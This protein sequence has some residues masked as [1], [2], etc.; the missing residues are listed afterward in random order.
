MIHI[1]F[2]NVSD[3]EIANRILR[4]II[5]TNYKRFEFHRSERNMISFYFIEKKLCPDV[6][7]Y[8]IQIIIITM[9]NSN[10]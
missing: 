5:T 8:M 7:V 1:S 3:F 4:A 2:S 10:K 9:T 6:I